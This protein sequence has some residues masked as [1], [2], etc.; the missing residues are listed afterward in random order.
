MKIAVLLCR[1][2]IPVSLRCCLRS[3]K[4]VI[5]LKMLLCLGFCAFVFEAIPHPSCYLTLLVDKTYH[6]PFTAPFSVQLLQL[7]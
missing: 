4:D 7:F 1:R 5:F 2:T 3:K 6:G